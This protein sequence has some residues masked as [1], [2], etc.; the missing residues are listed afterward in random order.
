MKSLTCRKIIILHT[1]FI[2][3]DDTY[4]CQCAARIRQS[5]IVMKHKIQFILSEFSAH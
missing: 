1:L 2:G 3:C 4:S 5:E